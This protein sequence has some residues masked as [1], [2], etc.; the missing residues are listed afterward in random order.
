MLAEES[1]QG[2]THN[3]VL[4]W[5][6]CKPNLACRCAWLYGRLELE[7]GRIFFWP[8]TSY[9]VGYLCRITG[10]WSRFFFKNYNTFRVGPYVC[11]TIQTSICM[12]VCTSV[13]FLYVYIV[14]NLLLWYQEFKKLSFCMFVFQFP[15]SGR[16]LK[17]NR[18]SAQ[19]QL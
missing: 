9:P 13:K 1:L 19:P 4:F 17:K 6:I 10:Y 16:I 15:L 11:M 8:D 2:Q 18:N 3:K 14:T 5:C 12:S 7:F